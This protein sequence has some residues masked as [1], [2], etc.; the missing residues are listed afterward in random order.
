MFLVR[1][2][3]APAHVEN[4]STPQHEIVVA[5]LAETAA[6]SKLPIKSDTTPSKPV[7]VNIVSIVTSTEFASATTP[8][9]QRNT[10]AQS[11]A[12]KAPQVRARANRPASPTPSLS[13]RL[14]RFLAGNG[15]YNVKPFP[16]VSTSGS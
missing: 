4:R 11:R 5:N 10:T 14:A 12:V 7:D 9:L 1:S 3:N 6:R 15:K 8:S 16:T 13:R 2:Y